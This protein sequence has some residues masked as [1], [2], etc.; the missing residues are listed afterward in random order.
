MIGLNREG[1]CCIYVVILILWDQQIVDTDMIA[2]RRPL[3]SHEPSSR[4]VWDD[5]SAVEIGEDSDLDDDFMA[6]QVP[7]KV[8]GDV[9]KASDRTK[10]RQISPRLEN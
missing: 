4:S 1:K 8:F 2:C 6:T 3:L 7:Y 10:Y 9:S 5:G